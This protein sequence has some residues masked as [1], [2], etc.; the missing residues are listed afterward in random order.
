[1]LPRLSLDYSAEMIDAF[2]YAAT[3]RHPDTL[4]PLTSH[5]AQRVKLMMMM[6]IMMMMM[7]DDDE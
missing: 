2:R 5:L 1:V 4:E 6:M 7:N 3:H